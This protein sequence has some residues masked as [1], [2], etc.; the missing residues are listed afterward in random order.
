MRPYIL[1]NEG[2]KLF[3]DKVR[4]LSNMTGRR[5]AAEALENVADKDEFLRARIMGEIRDELKRSWRSEIDPVANLHLKGFL[6]NSGEKEAFI[7]S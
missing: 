5:I 7:Y 3:V 1:Y 2:L 6:K 4:D